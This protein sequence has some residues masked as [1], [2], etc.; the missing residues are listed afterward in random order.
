[1]SADPRFDVRGPDEFE[2]RQVSY[3]PTHRVRITEP[4]YPVIAAG[5]CPACG[6]FPPCGGNA[7][8][9]GYA[10]QDQA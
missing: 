4:N 1:M 3:A 7:N 5:V 9:H 10:C 2:E 8:G 6:V